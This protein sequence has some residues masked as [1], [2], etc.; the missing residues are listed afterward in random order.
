MF[1]KESVVFDIVSEYPGTEE[2]FRSYDD[3]LGQCLMCHNLFDRLGDLE[4]RHGIRFEKISKELESSI[5]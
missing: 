3:F 2:V 4:E 1:T 5:K